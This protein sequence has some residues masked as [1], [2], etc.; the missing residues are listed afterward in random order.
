[1]LVDGYQVEASTYT[2]QVN[3]KGVEFESRI[4]ET[5][6]KI[7]LAKAQLQKA[8]SLVG[9]TSESYIAL[10]KL[11]VGSTEGVMNVNAQI[12]A[13]AMG[14]VNASASQSAGYSSSE[15]ETVSDSYSETH[16]FSH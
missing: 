14:A 13:S 3:A 6:A 8:L 16:T 1:M 2:A 9:S 10:K 11:Q 5:E 7:E 12:A 4:K 15:T